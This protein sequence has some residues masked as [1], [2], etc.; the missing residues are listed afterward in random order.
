M[1]YNYLGLV[2]DINRRLNEVELSQSNFSASSGFYSFAK[3]AI[4]SSIRNIN[5][6]EF[7]WPWNHAEETEIFT[8]GQ[9]R[10][11]YPYDAKTVNMDTFR[12]KRDAA[13]GVETT[14]VKNIVYEEWLDKYADYEYNSNAN[15]RGVPRVVSR[16]PSRELVFYP[17]PDK[18][19]ELVYEY[20]RLAHDLQNALDVP[21]LPEQYRYLIVDGAM[22]YVYQFRGDNQGSQLA[23]Q[24]FNKSLKN[25]RSIHIN[26]TDYLR[27]SRV[28]F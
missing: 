22:H 15:I 7:E 27:D 13:L 26:R 2:N 4:N 1:A 19:Y 3:D 17:A 24:A 14:K 5:Q 6:E 21:N 16:T 23:L 28:Y 10:Y 8:A 11:S 18:A 25:L 9:V 12:I 20:Y